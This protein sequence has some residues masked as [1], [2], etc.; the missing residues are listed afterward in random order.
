MTE[1]APQH[2]QMPC[3]VAKRQLL[4]RVKQYSRA[5]KQTPR[6]KPCDPSERQCLYH[7]LDRDNREP[8]HSQIDDI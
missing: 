6:Q 7:R 8:A 5:V 4:E 1:T 2:K 3:G